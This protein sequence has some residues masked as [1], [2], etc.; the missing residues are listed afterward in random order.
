[1]A[2]L[3]GVVEATSSPPPHAARTIALDSAATCS[4]KR[5]RD[6]NMQ[7]SILMV[8]DGELW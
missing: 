2:A 4:G 6:A 1:M 3:V 8:K 7:D 5:L